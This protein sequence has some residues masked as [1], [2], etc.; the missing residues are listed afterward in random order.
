[1]KC[2]SV[3]CIWSDS[4][5]VHEVTASTVLNY[6]ATLYTGGSDGSI[7]WWNLPNFKETKQD[8]KPIAM[9][10]GHAAP[11]ADLG[12]CFPSAVSGDEKLNDTNST[13][14]LSSNSPNCGALFSA[15]KDGVLCVWSRTS[16]HCRR[17]RKL[18]PWVGRPSMAQPLPGNRRY[19][20]IACTYSDY[21]SIHRKDEDLVHGESD[22]S[23]PSK[24]TIVVVDSYTLTTVQTVF[25]GTLSIGPL[26]SMSIILSTKH[27]EKQSIML[28]DLFGK[29]QLLP[30]LRD[31]HPDGGNASMQRSSSEVEMKDFSPATENRG[32]LVA[33]ASRGQV[34]VLLYATYCT[35]MLVDDGIKIGEIVFLDDQVCV[36][37]KSFIA[38]GTFLGDHDSGVMQDSGQSGDVFSDKFMVWNNR[39]SAVVYKILYSSN[40]FKSEPHFTIPPVPHSDDVKLSISFVQANNYILSIE[41]IAFHFKEALLWKPRITIW[42]PPQEPHDKWKFSGEC[43]QFGEGGFFDDW[44][45]NTASGVAG[46]TDGISLIISQED[47]TSCSNSLEKISVSNNR[48][49]LNRVEKI[50]SSSM[51]ISENSY[52]PMA[53]VYGFYDG[54]IEVVRLDV[55]FEGSGYYNGSLHHGS[56]SSAEKLCLSG[57]VG[58][59]LCLA[60]HRI[61]NV[62]SKWN[63]NH[64]LISGSMDSTVRIWDLVNGS[65]ILVMHQHVAPVRQIILPPPETE[66][67]WSD[68]FLSVADDLCVSLTSFDT[69]QVE[70]LFPGHPYYPENVVWDSARGYIA[71]LCPNHSGIS[72]THD[73]LYIWDVKTGARERVIRGAAAH[74]MFNHFCMGIKRKESSFS[75]LLHGNTSASSLILYMSEETNNSQSHLKN[76]VKGV[77]SSHTVPSSSSTKESNRAQAHAGK[78]TVA[79]SS[80]GSIF[81]RNK[82]AIE[83]S[84]PFPGIATLSF[85]LKSM[86][87]LCQGSEFSKTRGVWKRN[88]HPEIIRAETPKNSAQEKWDIQNPGTEDPSPHPVHEGGN[89]DFNGSPSGV[90]AD[91]EW[92]CRVEEC[93]LQFGLSFLH[94]WDVEHELDSLLISEMKLKRP[95]LLNVAS[96]LMGDRGSLT[97]AFPGS[98]ATLELWKSS[99]EYC[100]MRSL[101]MVSLTQHMISLS[102]SY[103]ASSSALAAFYT[104]NFAEKIPDIKPPLLQ[105][106]VSF[107]QDEFEHVRMA[108]RSLFH[109]A[110]SRAIP[111]PLCGQK[112]NGQDSFL[113]VPKSIAEDEAKNLTEKEVLMS[114]NE[115]LVVQGDSHTEDSDIL[116]WL[117]SFDVQDWIS[118]VGG[119]TQDAM[120]SHIIV[121]AALAVWYPS[122]VKPSLAMLTV[123]SLIKLVRAMN[124]KYS[125]TAAEILAEGMESTWRECID[126]EIPHLIKDIFFQIECVSGASTQNSAASLNIKETLVGILL[127]SLAMAD[128]PGFLNVI[129]RQIWSTAS[130]SPVH[131]ISLVTLI[132]VMRG[133]PRNLAIH[134]DKVLTF[135]LHTMDPS[136]VVLRRTCF[137]S[138]MVV[139]KELVLVFPM[140]ALNDTSTRLAVGDAIADINSAIIRVYDM[141]SVTKIKVLDAS[142]PPGLPSLLGGT[143]EVGVST[144]ISALSFSLD[145]EGLVAFSENGLMIRWW[146]LGSVW[147]EKISRNLTPVQCTKLIFV[148][149]WEGFSPSSTRSSI[150]ANVMVDAGQI[151]SKDNNNNKASGEMDRLNLLIHN[152]DLSYRL[153][154]AGE[155]KVKLKHHGHELGIFQ[156]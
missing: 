78:A 73:I 89:S 53:L 34:L 108:A 84:C 112:A 125:S 32:H 31:S 99:S 124:E 52:A 95:E 8:A 101:T 109:C 36:K 100:A 104:R 43:Q 137:Q 38:G 76:P 70:R 3:A 131:V 121:A 132:R 118:C 140:V 33:C 149:P 68:C 12:I 2:R 153:E 13:S 49:S 106:L 63:F 55:L 10:C 24:C 62:S 129:E 14:L 18:P 61:V 4:P 133:S 88:I 23:K 98:H 85:D 41:S 123:Q 79:E 72:D 47:E 22:Y 75:E 67:P 148:P 154:W 113:A 50:V 105:L 20:C 130:D 59:I 69:L 48:Y 134:L 107:W 19:V 37:D 11:I 30:I 138:S 86:M 136:N 54:T 117:E 92:L 120:T 44:I 102:N 152:L 96:G 7:I 35:F 5:P 21:Q 97:V 82:P 28:I 45:W 135:I 74:T 46:L 142:G 143:S 110:A 16:G 6:P 122:L 139:L 116:S 29:L 93:L 83:G 91:Y 1:M 126:T 94:L 111:R 155:R 42:L 56:S 39:G 15:C 114:F 27:I 77:S 26:K 103:S 65:P 51:V 156:L 115:E 66:C 17:R 150:M 64:V 25:H 144:A 9:L 80:M 57:H 147:W 90:T 87:S 60:A 128:V 127:P 145:G 81:P 141:Q 119:T 40:M 71:C 58:A 146:S 151:N